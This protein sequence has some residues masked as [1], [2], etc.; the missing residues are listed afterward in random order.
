[1]AMLKT[2]PGFS[3]PLGASITPAGINFA[4]FSRSA[5]TVVIELYKHAKDTEPYKSYNF[6]PSVN[7]TGDIWHIEIRGLK[8]GALYLYR[9]NGPSDAAAGC[10]FDFNCR[11]F[12]PYA[13]AFTEGSVFKALRGA[14]M[15]EFP[16]C[17]AADSGSF[18]WQGDT[19]PAI[20]L[21]DTVIYETHLRGYTVS[22]TSG[23]RY[24]GTFRGL[25]EKIPYLK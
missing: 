18:D 11:L 1:M 13:K 8:S 2:A 17:V 7:R 6:D 3:Y 9:I 21:C 20:P 25:T 24:P 23:V 15:E 14:G 4:V 16:K 10:R 5:L 22:P 19:P 12:D